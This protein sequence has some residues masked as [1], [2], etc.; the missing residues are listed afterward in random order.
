[1]SKPSKNINWIKDI[2]EYARKANSFVDFIEQQN[3]FSAL[4]WNNDMLKAT[5]SMR[6]LMEVA[7]IGNPM[8]DFIESQKRITEA[9]KPTFPSAI[10]ANIKTLQPY[11]SFFV[12]SPAL[13]LLNSI[14]NNPALK[15]VESINHQYDSLFKSIRKVTEQTSSFQKVLTEMNSWRFVIDQINLS[16]IKTENWSF[17]QDFQE[18]TETLFNLS[19]KALQ[20]EIS[21]EDFLEQSK[22]SIKINREWVQ[23]NSWWILLLI[24]IAFFIYPL[25]LNNQSTELI[26]SGINEIKAEIEEVRVENK[27]LIKNQQTTIELINELLKK[28][29]SFV[30]SKDE[31]AV[32]MSLDESSKV[33]DSIAKN[34]E[35]FIVYE[36]AEWS[37]INF[38]KHQDSLPK[39]GW[40]KTEK[41][42]E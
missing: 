13:D 30:T 4:G 31:I 24:D 36:E 34:T 6:G 40:V 17:L 32:Y 9:F 18:N 25:Y 26:S 35:V 7:K 33:L 22:E 29:V 8:A 16:A 19:E 3:K 10:S 38:K 23:R 21:P 5:Q 27:K 39:S 1:M 41:L 28:Q 12:Q 15:A 42:K 14:H 37:F 11:Q 2:Q 20:G